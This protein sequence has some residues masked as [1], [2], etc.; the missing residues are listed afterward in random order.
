MPQRFQPISRDR[1]QHPLEPA[2]DGIRQR[3]PCTCPAPLD[4][5]RI[6][7]RDRG[8]SAT[9]SPCNPEAATPGCARGAASR[10]RPNSTTAA[11]VAAPTTPQI[12]T[13]G[14]YRSCTQ[15]PERVNQFHGCANG[16]REATRTLSSCGPPR[17][18]L[19]RFPRRAGPIVRRMTN[20]LVPIEGQRPVGWIGRDSSTASTPGC[21][22]S[23]LADAEAGGG[24]PSADADSSTPLSGLALPATG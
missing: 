20:S 21:T 4:R 24:S 8:R 11:E 10:P 3:R 15:S 16:R 19:D 12:P 7:W 9:P 17:T 1:E 13:D 14:G 6:A 5:S 22:E 23:S 2:P 18:T